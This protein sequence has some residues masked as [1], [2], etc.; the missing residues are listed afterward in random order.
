MKSKIVLMLF[1]GVTIIS[2]GRQGKDGHKGHRGYVIYPSGKGFKLLTK[3]EYQWNQ[4]DYKYKT[5][6][7][8][9]EKENGTARIA[10]LCSAGEGR[11][12]KDEDFISTHY[13][14]SARAFSSPVANDGLVKAE[15]VGK[16][17]AKLVNL[18]SVIQNIE[19]DG[20]GNEENRP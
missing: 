5:Y 10:L 19:C 17:Q 6:F 14:S 16:W 3:C 18:Y 1:L 8:V 2:C 7:S 20:T 12:C 13:P 11:E 15:M 4:A 9:R